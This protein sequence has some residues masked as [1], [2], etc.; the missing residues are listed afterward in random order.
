[1]ALR[2][3]L[4]WRISRPSIE[5]METV[6]LLA[7]RVQ[8]QVARKQRLAKPAAE[9]GSPQLAGVM[10]DAQPR[11]RETASRQR[12]RRMAASSREIAGSKVRAACQ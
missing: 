7:P 9:Q 6:S 1:M 4:S 2:G 12:V 11:V 8:P 3:V 10:A 5:S